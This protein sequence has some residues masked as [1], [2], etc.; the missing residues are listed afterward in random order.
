MKRFS[1]ITALLL[2][3]LALAP[4]AFGQQSTSFRL[5]EQVFNAGGR[6]GQG[7]IGTS[8]SFRISL[9]A[10]GE[11]LVAS[12]PSSSSFQLDGGF[13]AA[14]PPPGEVLG[15]QFLNTTTLEWDPEGSGGLYNLYRGKLNFISNNNY[16]AACH[17][18]GIAATTTND[19]DVPPSG[20]G[21]YYFVTVENRLAEEGGNGPASDGTER[22][23]G[24]CP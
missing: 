9:E 1:S 24:P 18:Q 22:N 4:A 2:L 17:E 19:F 3:M 15:L 16:G 10:I 12:G 14:Y 6:P 5:E 7:G 20:T 13:V 21:L 8:T 23:S 11:S